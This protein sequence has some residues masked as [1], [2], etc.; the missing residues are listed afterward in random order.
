M[1]RTFGL[2]LCGGWLFRLFHSFKHMCA[3]VIFK[4][5]ALFE[6][7]KAAVRLLQAALK[8]FTGPGLG[9]R[10]CHDVYDSAAFCHACLM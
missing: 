9:G 8:R 2:S 1:P 3:E 7:F 6:T 5:L 4:K 10:A